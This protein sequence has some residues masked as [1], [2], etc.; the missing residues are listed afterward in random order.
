MDLLFV[1]TE[2]YGIPQDQSASFKNIDNWPRIRQIAWIVYSKDG[3]F[4]SANNYATSADVASQ[5]AISSHNSGTALL[6][7][8]KNFADVQVVPFTDSMTG[9]DY[10]RL[11]C[12]DQFGTK[13]FVNISSNI[14]DSHNCNEELASYI[15][16]NAKNLQV[17]TT[18]KGVL[19]LCKEVEYPLSDSHDYK[20]KT[21]LPIHKILDFFLES[22]HHCDVIIGHNIAYDVKVILCELYRYGKETEVL[23]SIQQFCTMQH[24]ISYCCFDTKKG[25]RYPKLQELFSKIFHQPFDNAHDAYFDIKATSDCFWALINTSYLRVEDY[26]FLI[27]SRK[28]KELADYYTK[29]ADS[30]YFALFD[31]KSEPRLYHDLNDFKKTTEERIERHNKICLS[32]YLKAAEL[33][34]S[35]SMF[36]AAQIL[37]GH[38]ND[39]D[40]AI[41]WFSKAVIE[42]DTLDCIFQLAR[43]CEIK[44][45]ILSNDTIHYYSI[46]KEKCIKQINRLPKDHLF[47]LIVAY[48][49]GIYGQKQDLNVAI[50][51]C[52]RVLSYKKPT[53]NKSELHYKLAELYDKKG[54]IEAAFQEYCIV[55]QET[56]NRKELYDISLYYMTADVLIERYFKGIGT[57]I[58]LVKAKQYIDTVLMHDSTDSTALYYLAQYY[59]NG[60]VGV[61][62]NI[63]TAYNYYEKA[64]R[65]NN[66]ALLKVGI[67]CLYGQGCKKDKK[68]AKEMFDLAAFK[69]LTVPSKYLKKAQS[70]F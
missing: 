57:R 9:E 49:E 51:L 33:G 44:Y 42:Y 65:S 63:V 1:D 45:G 41:K 38:Y 69:G 17:I 25:D 67:M 2:T 3:Q 31:N 48:K 13:T 52:E 64:S 11:V 50:S 59:E 53:V 58:D 16:H 61:E 26:P 29:A 15:E 30:E 32:L 35:Y 20:S 56:D 34:N 55:L 46:W 6:D 28:K 70:L 37:Y 14:Q 36:R 21:I 10:S 47:K 40:G 22:L 5:P 54:D 23:E 24:S 19:V 27:S 68:K 7:F 66:E 4:I 43:A 18:K 39:L 8:V 60:L 62:K 12:I